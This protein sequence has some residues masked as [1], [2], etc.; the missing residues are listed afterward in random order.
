MSA[1]QTQNTRSTAPRG[2]VIDDLDREWTDL[3][4]SGQFTAH[5][6]LWLERWPALRPYFRTD[7]RP[8]SAHLDRAQ[9]DEI[10]RALLTE[11]AAGS[12]PA[13]R[14]VL[15]CM[16]GAAVTIAR[17]CQGRFSTYDDAIAETVAALWTAIARFPID[18]VDRV[19]GRLHFAVLDA[20]AGRRT[21]KVAEHEVPLPFDVLDARALLAESATPAVLEH[22]LGI[23]GEVLEVIAW[24][25]D[26]R[27][28]TT[29]EAALVTRLYVIDETGATPDGATVAA[30]LGITHAA[31][32]QRAHRAV[33]RLAQA[34]DAD[35]AAAGARL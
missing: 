17:R 15:Q 10:L 20:V 31:L 30:E 1:T 5:T 7:T 23:T 14:M 2:Q 24:G 29:D 13:G 26:T 3:V 9:A 6:E 28:L 19:A 4:N 27:A 33:R 25:V 35:N 32:R 11:H 22:A 34:V 8:A 21:I 18:H 16:L 12:Y